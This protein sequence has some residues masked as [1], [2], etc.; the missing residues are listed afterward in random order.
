MPGPQFADHNGCAVWGIRPL[1]P[2]KHWYRGFESH[3]SHKYLSAYAISFLSVP[4]LGNER[5]LLFDERTVRLFTDWTEQWNPSSSLSDGDWMFSERQTGS[6]RSYIGG[7]ETRNYIAGSQGSQA[8]SARPSGRG[9]SSIWR[10]KG[11]V[12]VKLWS[13]MKTK[14][15]CYDWGAEFGCQLNICSRIE[16]AGRRTL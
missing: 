4:V 8:V 13:D 12:T 6:E 7:G 2:L 10:W 5:V 11:C 1:R 16:L 9:D 3:S 14:F 15:W